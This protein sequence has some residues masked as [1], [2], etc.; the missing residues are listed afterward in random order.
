MLLKKHAAAKLLPKTGI[1]WIRIGYASEKEGARKIR[2]PSFF[3]LRYSNRITIV[4][5]RNR[6]VKTMQKSL[7]EVR[8]LLK[9]FSIFIYTGNDLD[10]AALMESE[11]EDLYEMKL[12]E[13]DEY[14]QAR[15]IL[16]Q[17]QAK[18]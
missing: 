4:T 16:K 1:C 14:L 13:D 18:H 3:R 6:L 2:V 10:D 5:D 15:L 8:Q 11:L 17:V 12:I 9:R 7:F